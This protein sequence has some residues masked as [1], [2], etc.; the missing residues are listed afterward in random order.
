MSV[1]ASYRSAFTAERGDRV[2]VAGAD[3]EQK[4]EAV[5]LYGAFVSDQVGQLVPSVEAL[6]AAYV[7]GDDETAR[8]MFRHA[9]RRSH[10][11]IGSRGR[12]AG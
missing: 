9:T 10:E 5:S 6:V 12:G 8:E 11:R 3:A 7:A 2:E 4:A 1:M